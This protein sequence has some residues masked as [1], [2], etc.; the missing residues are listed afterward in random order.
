MEQCMSLVI[1][2]R[3][4]LIELLGRLLNDKLSFR[5]FAEA[6]L[7]E[8]ND[9]TVGQIWSELE[10]ELRDDLNPDKPISLSNDLIDL[11]KRSI[12]FLDTGC[13]YEWPRSPTTSSVAS[14]VIVICLIVSISIGLATKSATSY[15]AAVVMLVFCAVYQIVRS[16]IYRTELIRW[17]RIGNIEIWP[18]R[19][20]QDYDQ[21]Q[22]GGRKS[23]NNAMK[24]F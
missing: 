4:R 5:V 21:A 9:R 20:L 14:R 22:I 13:E 7:G 18:F 15:A 16:R 3:Q 19:N 12:L 17:Q 24:S 23:H 1:N 6:Q 10:D 11:L 8:S 2:D